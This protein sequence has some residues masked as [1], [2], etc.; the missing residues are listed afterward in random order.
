MDDENAHHHHAGGGLEAATY[1]GSPPSSR[2]R[3]PRA[4]AQAISATVVVALN[5]HGRK[6]LFQCCDGDQRDQR[7]S[8][9][10]MNNLLSAYQAASWDSRPSDFFT[11]KK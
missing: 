11:H 9:D 2:A 3:A 7:I 5:D 8:I 10:G 1:S 6:L 4:A